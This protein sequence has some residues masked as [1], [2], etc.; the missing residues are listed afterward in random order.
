MPK[1]ET[2]RSGGVTGGLAAG[3]AIAATVVATR[4]AACATSNDTELCALVDRW[5][6]L[7]RAG[8]AEVARINAEQEAFEQRFPPPDAI[9]FRPEDAK[10]GLPRPRGDNSHYTAPIDQCDLANALQRAAGIGSIWATSQ[11]ARIAEIFAG[12]NAWR[13]GRRTAAEPDW[14]D[15]CDAALRPM[16]DLEKQIIAIRATTAAGVLAK[17]RIWQED[18]YAEGMDESILEDLPGVLVAV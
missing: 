5:F 12:Y 17:L 9:R 16:F 11:M 8:E 1:H 6:E 13:H 3:T 15:L 18:Y 4:A 7:R 14:S 10:L 2:S